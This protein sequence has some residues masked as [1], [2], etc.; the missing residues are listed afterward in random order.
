MVAARVTG[1]L[2]MADTRFY[3]PPDRRDRLAA[4]YASEADGRAGRAAEGA[5]DKARTSR[6]RAARSPVVQVSSRQR[7]TM[8]ASWR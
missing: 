3:V 7:A 2:K 6:V 4:V 1:P 8:A 5:R